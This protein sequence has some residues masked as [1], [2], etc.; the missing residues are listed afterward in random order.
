MRNKYAEGNKHPRTRQ[1]LAYS[2]DEDHAPYVRAKRGKKYLPTSYDDRPKSSC[3]KNRKKKEKR[4]KRHSIEVLDKDG[5]SFW[6]QKI[7]FKDYCE[8]N[9]IPYRVEDLNKT[10]YVDSKVYERVSSGCKYG[11]VGW[12]H[13]KVPETGRKTIVPIYGMVERFDWIPTGEV[14]KVQ[15]SYQIGLRLTWW[16]D[17]DIGIEYILKEE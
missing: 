1:E 2:M 7:N 17:K 10:Y 11:V 5:I 9:D 13:T 16:S 15:R 4:G 12:N 6:R 8:K 14:K 3:K